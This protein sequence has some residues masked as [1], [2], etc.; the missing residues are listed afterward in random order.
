MICDLIK[1]GRIGGASAIGK[2][3]DGE[4]VVGNLVIDNKKV[5]I[6]PQNIGAIDC[7]DLLKNNTTNEISIK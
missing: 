7:L 4:Y 5:F 1:I 2:T 6:S 3:K